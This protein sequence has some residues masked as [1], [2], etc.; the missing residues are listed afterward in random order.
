MVDY[1]YA[2]LTV[3]NKEKRKKENSLS[4]YKPPKENRRSSEKTMG[5]IVRCYQCL[6]YLQMM[7]SSRTDISV[8]KVKMVFRLFS[9]IW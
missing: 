3:K 7:T 5:A 4:S 2:L 9:S 1:G 6:F 8:L